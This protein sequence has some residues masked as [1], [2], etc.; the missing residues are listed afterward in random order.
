MPTDAEILARTLRE[1]TDLYGRRRDAD[2][3]D[4]VMTIVINAQT[5]S[6][7]SVREDIRARVWAQDGW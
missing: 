2:Y 4:R 1:L 6:D 7:P 3:A 5:A